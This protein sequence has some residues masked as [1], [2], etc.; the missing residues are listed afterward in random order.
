MSWGWVPQNLKNAVGNLSVADIAEKAKEAARDVADAAG[1]VSDT[2]QAEY[3][4]TFVELD[5]QV[6]TVRPDLL[7]IEF[8]SDDKID[9][10]STRLNMSYAQRMLILN[11]SERRYSVTK[12]EGEVVDVNFRG[13]PAPPL[14]LLM[15][16]CI[17]AQH[18]LESDSGNVIVVH[19]FSGYTRST[20]FLSCFLA[21]RGMYSSPVDALHRVCDSVGIDDVK[22]I[23]PSQRRY[24]TYFQQCQQGLSPLRKRLR[25]QRTQLNGV[26]RFESDGNVIFRPYLEVWNH[27]ELVYTSFESKQACASTEEPA[28]FPKGFS[29]S[30]SCVS[31]I[32][33]ADIWVDGDVLVRVRHVYPSGDRDTA[34]R[35]TFHTGFVSEGLQIGKR[36]LDTA[37][38]DPRFP[39]DFFMDLIF[40]AAVSPE[41]SNDAA[42]A[43][44]VFDKARELSLRLQQEERVRQ[45]AEAKAAAEATAAAGSES[46]EVLRLEETLRA[47]PTFTAEDA[48]V[49]ATSSVPS[50]PV[51]LR[52]ALAAAAAEDAG[53]DATASAPSTVPQPS[54]AAGGNSPAN[55]A[56]ETRPT[57]AAT[58]V[59][60]PSTDPKATETGKT[61]VK[62]SQ[63]E[64]DQLFSDFDAA[65]ESVGGGTVSGKTPSAQP[66]ETGGL[67]SAAK[68]S[69]PTDT[70][71]VFAECDAFL[72]ELDG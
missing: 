28:E 49:A 34:L 66:A 25:L 68:P 6:F 29:A 72:K 52:R 2:V 30:D 71:D 27:G 24:L 13:L 50:N 58:P 8:P 37:C 70:A 45:E 16:L 59:P 22:A 46:D 43:M 67:Q 40:E 5:C 14:E 1:K 17:S 19:C 56:P 15:E 60:M 23:V 20:V 4:R 48:G 39:E 11:M 57:A 47:A 44:A 12:F 53:T 3:R 42:Q 7:V 51:E 63:E 32:L 36:D 69:A 54:A 21:F 18:W 38:D 41:T 62:D 64:I 33:P 10:L 55:T 31:F 26:P 9:R 65:L 61:A 35:L